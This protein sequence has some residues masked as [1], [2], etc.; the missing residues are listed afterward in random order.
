M[1]ARRSRGNDSRRLALP[2]RPGRGRPTREAE[3]AHQT[4][5]KEWCDAIRWRERRSRRRARL[6][7]YCSA[8]RAR[9]GDLRMRRGDA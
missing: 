9:E 8:V 4:E 1:G 5:L 7:S 6:Q 3:Q 2:R